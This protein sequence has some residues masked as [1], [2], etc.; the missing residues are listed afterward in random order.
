MELNDDQFVAVLY[1]STRRN[2][3]YILVTFDGIA[4]VCDRVHTVSD[5][6]PIYSAV[7]ALQ[8]SNAEDLILVTRG[9]FALVRLEQYQN[10]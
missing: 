1:L 5:S 7:N 6:V 9:K 3:T 8:S 2:G 10:A 4:L